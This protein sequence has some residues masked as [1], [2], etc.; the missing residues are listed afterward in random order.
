MTLALQ[1]ALCLE[2]L[3]HLLNPKTECLST[4][5]A[6][7]D[8][9]YIY[10]GKRK[11]KMTQADFEKVR[12]AHDQLEKDAG[13]FVT[14]YEL[15]QT[16]EISEQKLKAGFLELYQQTIWNYANNLRMNQAAR[17]LRDTDC[18]IHEIAANVGYQSPAA[19]T[20]MFKNWCGLTPGQSRAQI[21]AEA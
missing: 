16:F 4:I 20:N 21:A 1:K 12:K 6:S 2:F 19:F 9:H 8:T 3:A 15:S 5:P 10:V 11:I 17:L 7:S 18:N 13:S 14:I